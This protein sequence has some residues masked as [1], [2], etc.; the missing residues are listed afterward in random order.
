MLMQNRGRV[1]TVGETTMKLL[2]I[3]SIDVRISKTSTLL[4]AI[5]AK[6][7]TQGIIGMDFLIP[8]E[9]KLDFATCEL[10]VNGETIR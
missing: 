7:K 8:T 3:A 1:L 2:G 9:G 10:M 6:I 5:F 4:R